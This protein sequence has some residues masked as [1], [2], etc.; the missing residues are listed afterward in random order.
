MG[1]FPK[2]MEEDYEKLVS[3]DKK[4][5]S[6]L[7]FGNRFNSDQTLYEY[8]IE[9]LLVFVSAKE[10]ELQGGK[11]Q[12]HD[13]TIE[14][15]LSYWVEP[16]MALRRFIFYNKAKKKGSIP[17][18]DMAYRA[19]IE[20]LLSKAETNDIE[21]AK[22]YIENI[23]DLFRGYAVVIKNRFW[24]AR[25]LMPICP[26]FILCGADPNEKKRRA[27]VDWENN[28]ESVDN[29]FSFDKHNFL[30]RGGELYYLQLIQGLGGNEE[31]KEELEYLLNDLVNVQCKKIS[32]IAEYVQN[33]W[34]E[35]YCMNKSCLLKQLNLTFIPDSGYEKCGE[36][37]VEELLN[38][39]SCKLHPINRI[40][41]LAKGVMFQIMRM[42]S[43]RVADYLEQNSIA[44]IVDMRGETTDTV[45]KI[46]AES[47]QK[48]ESDF[49]TAI[50][51]KA[52]EVG[53]K[54]EEFMKT[55][56]EARINSLDIF[57][58]KG[59]ELQCIIPANGAFERFSLSEDV[60]RFL[61]L[62]LIK[63]GD[64]MTLNMF[65]DNLYKHYSIVIGPEEYKKSM[66]QAAIE[67][68][69]TN[70]FTDNAIAFSE[71]LNA[72]GFLKELSDATSIVINPYES[73][74]RG[75]KA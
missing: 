9:F 68:T 2:W 26:E 71:F 70:S 37:S 57:K 27:C 5:V 49:M 36:Y 21:D 25:A 50:N 3:G 63:P 73:I 8:L 31:K 44:W 43:C 39:L 69:L 14:K 23:Q 24:G 29:V 32:A 11:M 58:S 30:A 6:T 17:A 38:Y 54:E 10:G 18:D 60:I 53:V 35:Q 56:R 46:A 74:Q 75:V 62:S 52:R 61:V 1:T 12:F 66:A 41:I 7:I 15:K 65:L 59:K 45:K 47:Y 33:T 42:M 48:L 34:E 55:V 72:T 40:E 67:T 20:L 13:I 51:K 16:R 64:K 19:M 22:E 4:P 28:P